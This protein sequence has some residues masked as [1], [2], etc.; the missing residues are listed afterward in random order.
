MLLEFLL[1]KC[2]DYD[3]GRLPHFAKKSVRTTQCG[4]LETQAYIL[5]LSFHA[6]LRVLLTIA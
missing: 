1:V 3:H 5:T 4:E 6:G 2:V